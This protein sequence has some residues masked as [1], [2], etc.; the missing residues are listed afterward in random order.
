MFRCAG[1]GGWQPANLSM[2]E[3]LFSFVE[4]S[5]HAPSLSTLNPD[6]SHMLFGQ[7]GQSGQNPKITDSIGKLTKT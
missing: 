5:N 7:R 1:A 3:K 6:L 4:I 2:S